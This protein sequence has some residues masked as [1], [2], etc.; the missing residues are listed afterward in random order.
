MTFLYALEFVGVTFDFM[1][2]KKTRNLIDLELGPLE[3]RTS[4]LPTSL[5]KWQKSIEFLGN[6]VVIEVCGTKKMVNHE[7]R[8]IMVEAFRKK[9]VLE[10]QVLEVIKGFCRK[11]G[12][13]MDSWGNYFKCSCIYSQNQNLYVS[14]IDKLNKLTFEIEV[15]GFN[16]ADYL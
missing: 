4:I 8:T 12:L 1:L 2:F 7:E 6:D 9:E 3:A 15:K 11:Y 13:N 10:K 14:I 5:V 16:Q